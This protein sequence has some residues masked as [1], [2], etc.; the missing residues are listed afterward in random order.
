MKKTTY[1]LYNNKEKE[2]VNFLIIDINW[3]Y[4]QIME[5]VKIHAGSYYSNIDRVDLIFEDVN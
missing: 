4:I 5:A 2:Y 3:T 1:H